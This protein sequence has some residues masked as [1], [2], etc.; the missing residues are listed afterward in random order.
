MA[1]GK[2]VQEVRYQQVLNLAHQRQRLLSQP[3]GVR[4]ARHTLVEILFH[5]ACGEDVAQRLLRMFGNRVSSQPQVIHVERQET[6]HQ[7]F[8]LLPVLLVVGLRS[9][10]VEAAGTVAARLLHRLDVAVQH[11][12]ELKRVHFL[13]LEP[14]PYMQQVAAHRH[15]LTGLHRPAELGEDI[16]QVSVGHFILSVADGLTDAVRGVVAYARHDTAGYGGQQVTPHAEVDAVVEN[17]SPLSG[18][19]CSP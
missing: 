2:V 15:G 14:D 4:H 6:E 19:V 10:I 17:F 7:P 11:G 5:R 18:W 12:E 8:Y 9:G 13:A 1:Q 16:G 3:E